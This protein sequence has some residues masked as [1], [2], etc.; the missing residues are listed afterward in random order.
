LLL[1]F[2]GERII[3]K[4]QLLIIL[5]HITNMH[6][7]KNLAI[8]LTA[9]FV[10]MYAVMFLNVSQRDHIYLS[11]TRFY[12]AVLMVAAMAILMITILHAMYPN[13]LR[14]KQI[15]AASVVVFV[16]TLL[17]L[18][19]QRWLGD[20]QYMKAMIPHHSSAILTSSQANIIDPQARQLA[21]DIIKAQQEEIAQMKQ[22]IE[23]LK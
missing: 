10:I 21:D 15:I 14:N 8:S 7:Y 16:I 11:I 6:S 13:P 2:G 18:R 19:N 12:M 22:L 9:S 4:V 23:K 1:L 20:V 5:L 17:A 3:V